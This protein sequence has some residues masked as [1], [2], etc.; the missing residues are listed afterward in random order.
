MFDAASCLSMAL[1]GVLRYGALDP[2]VMDE[3]ILLLRDVGTRV[4]ALR[5]P[6]RQALARV[7]DETRKALSPG[8]AARIGLAIDRAE[9]AITSGGG[10]DELQPVGRFLFT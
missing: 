8:R 4:P 1:D 10:I 6:A 5:E 2:E 9:E 7:R 3:L